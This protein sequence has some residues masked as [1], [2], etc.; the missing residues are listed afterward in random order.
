MV[1]KVCVG[2]VMNTK[3]AYKYMLLQQACLKRRSVC[4][5]DCIHCEFYCPPVRA[6]EAFDYT[7]EILKSKE[8]ELY[9]ISNLQYLSNLLNKKEIEVKE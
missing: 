1:W 8:P 9:F 6:N 5:K 3:I 4:N 7:L 2:N